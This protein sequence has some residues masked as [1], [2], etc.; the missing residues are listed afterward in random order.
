MVT[1]IDTEHNLCLVNVKI[2]IL[3]ER[4]KTMES[5]YYICQFR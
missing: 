2:M 5:T 4:N 1:D 3:S